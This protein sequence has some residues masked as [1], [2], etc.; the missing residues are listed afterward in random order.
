MVT[1]AASADPLQLLLCQVYIPLSGDVALSGRYAR[2]IHGGDFMPAPEEK[3]KA[4]SRRGS[5]FAAEW[6]QP[7]QPRREECK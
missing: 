7:P 2:R 4:P 6:H 5:A 1:A 3:S